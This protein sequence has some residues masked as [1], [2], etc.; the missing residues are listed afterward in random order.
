M[1]EVPSISHRKMDLRGDFPIFRGP[2][3]R[4]TGLV[5]L[6]S[7]ASAQKP[8]EVIEAISALYGESYANIHRGVYQLSEEAT[9]LFEG[10]REK[11]RHFLN[12]ARRE[13]IVFVR[14]TTEGMNL[15]A[16]TLGRQRVGAGDE[17][18]LTHLEH[19][20]NIVPWQMLCQSTGATLKVAPINEAGE[21]DL[22]AFKSLFSERT[23]IVSVT[24]VSNALGTINPV[25]EMIALARERGVPVIVDGAQAVP[26]FA[27]DVQELDCDF[28]V[29]SGHK[30][31]GPTG[32]GA[33]YGRF[34]LL[35]S[36]P[37]WQGGGDMIESVTFEKTTYA[38]LPMRM[39]AGT[40]DIAGA[41]GLGAAIDYLEGIGMAAIEEHGRH[42][43]EYG[44]KVLGNVPG[45]RIFGTAA[46]KVPVF[47]FVLD[48]IHP[49]DVG[50][51]L[52][53]DNIAVRTG[54]HCAQPVMDRFGVPATTRASLGLYNNTADLDALAR[55]IGKLQ[56]FFGA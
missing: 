28:Y 51:L 54:H 24:H 6:D 42:L 18:L 12:A 34:E 49:H 46:Q 23:K 14:G 50:T 4:G 31:Y 41:V 43:L 40:P 47:S 21:V 2:D 7:G 38:P 5:Y 37:P 22:D 32:I 33:I 8:D 17:I 13:E 30:M 44:N 3:G 35:D 9:R 48:G 19:H 25:R 53:A 45:L 20:A 11:V 15:L 26:H 55:G 1:N 56:R 39:E 27:V 52:A 16:N 10:A 36:L 29:F